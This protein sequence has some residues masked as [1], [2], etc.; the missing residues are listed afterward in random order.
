MFSRCTLRS[1]WPG[2]GAEVQASDRE[3][4][5]EGEEGEANRSGHRRALTE[6]FYL[7]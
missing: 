2:P 1:T 4:G 6:G 5:E 7:H 3:E